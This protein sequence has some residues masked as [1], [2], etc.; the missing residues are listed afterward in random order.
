[1]QNL[2]FIVIGLTLI[3][4]CSFWFPQLNCELISLLQRFCTFNQ[5]RFL[6]KTKV[7]FK[8]DDF[9]RLLLLRK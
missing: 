2:K 4:N 8:V 7:S 9:S 1:M 5:L 3:E 6:K